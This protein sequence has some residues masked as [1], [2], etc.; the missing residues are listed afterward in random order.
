MSVLTNDQNKLRVY[1]KG[2][3]ERIFNICNKDTIPENYKE[4]IKI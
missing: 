2:S 4:M 3:P 1:T